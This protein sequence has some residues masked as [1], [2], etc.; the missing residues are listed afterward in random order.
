MKRLYLLVAILLGFVFVL[1][2]CGGNS[3]STNIKVDM[4]EFM[5]SPMD[6]S[7][8]AGKEITIELS[9]NGAVMHDF[10]IMKF[11]TEVGQ[12]FNEEDRPNVYWEA[13]LEPGTSKTLTFT[14]PSDPGEYQVVCGVE[15]HYLA[16]MLAKMIVVAE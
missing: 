5:F 2:A 6:F 8:P 16:G 1:T 14:A 3:P 10:I 7:V 4:S 15:G 13:E 11:G 12:D 9:N